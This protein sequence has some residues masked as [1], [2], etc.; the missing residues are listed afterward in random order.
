MTA[1]DTPL[2]LRYFLDERGVLAGAHT[3]PSTADDA[4]A[5]ASGQAS[6]Q[7]ALLLADDASQ[8]RLT[9]NE[10]HGLLTTW[11]A[12]LSGPDGLP[13]EE[14]QVVLPSDSS[15]LDVT[16]AEPVP[17][18]SLAWVELPDETP[19]IVAEHRITAPEPA[20]A[21]LEPFA[22]A[23]TALADK[24]HALASMPPAQ[25]Q[26]FIAEQPYGVATPLVDAVLASVPACDVTQVV[27]S[28]FIWSGI[29]EQG[30]RPDISFNTLETLA[31]RAGRSAAMHAAF[32]AASDLAVELL[33]GQG[34]SPLLQ[35]ATS[36]V[37]TAT[38]VE[39]D[40]V[41]PLTE[42]V[43]EHFFRHLQVVVASAVLYD[44]ASPNDMQPPLRAWLMA[45]EGPGEEFGDSTAD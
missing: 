7:L 13:A 40:K 11:Y 12:L 38:G 8:L 35:E 4:A 42:S 3:V 30:Y 16:F 17:A 33:G 36:L 41:L 39:E 21:M 22:A 31:A 29:M 6:P 9:A 20:A 15:R 27:A 10:S 2:S 18:S 45:L 25:N 32:G 23:A 44:V 19:V 28:H 34:P 14:I 1:N 5:Q 24:L 26:E 37:A 43:A